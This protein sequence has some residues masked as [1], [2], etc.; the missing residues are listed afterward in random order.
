MYFSELSCIFLRLIVFF[1]RFAVFFSAL[2]CFSELSCGLVCLVSFRRP[3]VVF[4]EQD[5]FF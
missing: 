3:L 2:V 4:P 1:L 5:V